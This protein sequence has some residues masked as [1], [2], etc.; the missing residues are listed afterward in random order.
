MC[1]KFSIILQFITFPKKY[2]CTHH[3]VLDSPGGT[4][5]R[6]CVHIAV[7]EKSYLGV[8]EQKRLN[9][10]A[11]NYACMRLNVILGKK[12]LFEICNIF[13]Y[14]LYVKSNICSYYGYY[15]AMCENASYWDFYC[16]FEYLRHI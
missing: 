14:I 6:K 3:S 13:L 4:T 2:P 8:R 7:E 9:T 15:E 1:P 5:I 10:T 12:S 16:D 11:L